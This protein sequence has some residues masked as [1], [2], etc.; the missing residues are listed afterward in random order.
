ML[1][2]GSVAD[3]VGSALMLVIVDRL[4]SRQRLA[5]AGDRDAANHLVLPCF[6]PIFKGVAI[7][8]FFVAA[9]FILL[10][11]LV[12][13]SD[14]FFVHL[15]QCK[16]YIACCSLSAAPVLMT[17]KSISA[18]SFKTVFLRLMPWFAVSTVLTLIGGLKASNAPALVFQAVLAA[19]AL[20]PIIYCTLLTF[21]ILWCRVNFA[22]ASNRACIQQLF[23][24]SLLLLVFDICFLM[25]HAGSAL[26]W[27]AVVCVFGMHVLVA[28]FPISLYRTFLADTKFWRGLGQHNRG[29]IR[30]SASLSSLSFSGTSIHKSSSRALQES[31][32]EEN[33][34][35]FRDSEMNVSTASKQFQDMMNEISD[36]MIDFAFIE[37]GP[38]IGHGASAEVLLGT[39]QSKKVAIKVS[40][41]P[42]IT[43][44]VLDSFYAEALITSSLDHPNIVKFY[45]ICVRPPEIGMVIEYCSRGNLKGSLTSEASEWTN[46]RR[47]LA[48]LHAARAVE[49]LHSQG[50]IHRDVKADNFFVD[51]EWNIKLGDFGESVFKQRY[52][53]GR[54]MT[55]LGTVAFMAPELVEGKPVYT[56]AI[57]VYALGITMWEIWT[58][59]DPFNDTTTFSIYSKV[60]SGERPPI[61]D[62]A[63]LAFVDIMC[64][65][66]DQ[67]PSKRPAAHDVVCLLEAVL[68]NGEY[69]RK[70]QSSV[71]S[72]SSGGQSDSSID[73]KDR[74]YMH[75]IEM[76]SM[77]PM[78]QDNTN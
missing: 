19:I 29:G 7:Q 24:F 68:V 8:Y 64:R 23:Y 37:V 32:D 76:S 11:L 4:K 28:S 10:S 45:G 56:E 18:T 52:Q 63:P 9:I 42:E 3:L 54:R 43:E 25:Q 17:Q 67:D 50:V 31:P 66:W 57:D 16:L 20:F 75:S 1:F 65:S 73:S 33:I 48:A 12:S 14:N 60:M 70:P 47:I 49:Y 74:V 78:A 34:E 58:G 46:H 36:V 59:L 35:T 72:K 2:A 51:E 21:K 13:A 15:I 39:Y 77:N 53:V 6:M 5:Y 62:D 44:E 38:I 22:S 41:P 40:A 71:F 61:P 69:S 30:R 27:I 26:K 55:V